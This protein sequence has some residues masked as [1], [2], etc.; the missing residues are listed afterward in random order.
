MLVLNV[1]EALNATTS[2][3][4]LCYR[5]NYRECTIINAFKIDSIYLQQV[6][7]LSTSLSTL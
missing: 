4:L 3:I 6:S 7:H 1:H 2:A 5:H